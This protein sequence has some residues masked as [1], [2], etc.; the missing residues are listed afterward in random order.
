MEPPTDQQTDQ[1]RELLWDHTTEPQTERMKGSHSLP[2]SASPME[3]QKER[4][5]DTQKE[6]YSA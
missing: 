1:P 6:G 2:P 3:P 4:R 5:L